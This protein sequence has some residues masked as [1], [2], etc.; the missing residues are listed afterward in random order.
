MGCTAIYPEVGGSYFMNGT[1]DAAGAILHFKKVITYG[2]EVKVSRADYFGSKQKGLAKREEL[3]KDE[4]DGFNYKYF[5]MP[6][7]L[8][9]KSELY[10]GWGLMFFDGTRVKKIVEAPLKEADNE[11]TLYCLAACMHNNYHQKVSNLMYDNYGWKAYYEIE[12]AID[13][14]KLGQEVFNFD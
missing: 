5:L 12:N 13:F 1:I 6:P 3:M 9:K 2:I 10:R 8:I 11:R 7:N 4:K 14:K